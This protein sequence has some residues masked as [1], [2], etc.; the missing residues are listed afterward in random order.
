[1]RIL[2]KEKGA[3]KLTSLGLRDEDLKKV[4]D[5]NRKTI[6]NHLDFWSYWKR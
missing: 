5:A 6:W 4:R 2:D 3:H 1:M